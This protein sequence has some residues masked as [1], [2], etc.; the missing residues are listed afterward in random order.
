M[1]QKEQSPP[2]LGLLVTFHSSGRRADAVSCAGGLSRTNFTSVSLIKSYRSTVAMVIRQIF[3]LVQ[4]LVALGYDDGE[5]GQS[6]QGWL[7]RPVPLPLL[8]GSHSLYCF[9]CVLL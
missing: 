2:S 7:D 5:L 9:V 4:G 1:E 8:K 3:Y 6:T